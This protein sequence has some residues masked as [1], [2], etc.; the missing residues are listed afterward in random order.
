MIS[1]IANYKVRDAVSLVLAALRRSVSKKQVRLI[2][3][4]LLDANDSRIVVAIE[5][6][7]I[8]ME[9]IKIW[10]GKGPCKLIVLGKIPPD[11]M[12][13]LCLRRVNWPLEPFGWHSSLPTPAYGFKESAAVIHYT[14]LLERFGLKHWQRALERFD[15]SNE[16]NNLGFGGCV[17]IIQYGHYQYL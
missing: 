16:W 11:L 5:P 3:P 1:L 4:S 14:K 6:D 12:D 17:K 13:F 7:E 9:R 15:F 2:S 10:M 8:M